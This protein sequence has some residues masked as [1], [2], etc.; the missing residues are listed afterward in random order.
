MPR[1]LCP[2][3]HAH[4]TGAGTVGR[5]CS[6]RGRECRL[7]E[8]AIGCSRS[9]YTVMQTGSEGYLDIM[10]PLCAGGRSGQLKRCQA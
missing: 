5:S 1:T 7:C 4:A 3:V 6:A 2:S 10:Q 9:N 8:A